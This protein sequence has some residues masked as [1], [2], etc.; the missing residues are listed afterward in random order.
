[1]I[2]EKSKQEILDVV[3]IEE[4]VGEFVSLKRRGINLMGL[5]PF[6]GEKSPSFN[7]NP[8]K[9]IFKCFGCGKAGDAVTFLREHE[10]MSFIDALKWIA[11]KYNIAVEEK[12]LSKEDFAERQV[13][14]SLFLINEFAKDYYQ[15]TM[16]DTDFGRSIGLSYFKERG[17]IED[18]ITKFGLGFAPDQGDALTKAALKAGYKLELL[19]KLK[20]TTDYEKDFFR[21]RVIFPIHN[22]SGKVI[23]F[24]GRILVKDPKAPKYVNSPETEIYYKSKVLYAM[25][26]A[27]KGIA[28]L[29]ECILTEGYTDVISLHQAGIDN[30]VAS[31]GTSLTVEQIRLIK[32]FTPNIK[33]L[34]DGDAAGIKAA[35]RGLDLV[36]E[37]NMNVKIVLL[38]DGEDPDSYV[39]RV[40]ATA[41]RAFINQ[42]AKDFILFKATLLKEETQGDPIKKVKLIR[43]LLDTVA[44]IPDPIKRSIYIKECS[45]LMEVEEQYLVNE[46]NKIVTQTLSKDRQTAEREANRQVAQQ[47]REQEAKSKEII[48][49]VVPYEE[50][51]PS[52]FNE[53]GIDSPS[54]PSLAPKPNKTFGDEFQ[55][56]DII[57]ILVAS[58]EQILDKKENLTV[59]EFIVSQ[60]N[61]VIE[62]FD[63]KTYEKMARVALERLAKGEPVHFQ[64][65][66]Q[67]DD[68]SV[69]QTAYDLASTPYEYSENW[70]KKLNM[71]LQTQKLPEL[72]FSKDTI[73]A[74]MRFKL[75]RVLRLSDKNQALLKE[76]QQKG[77]TDQLWVVLKTQ[78]RLK[79]MSSSI[80]KQLGTVIL[81]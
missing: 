45:A 44:K 10:S 34:Y 31:S 25:H 63:N 66:A 72:N 57:R 62:D 18:T 35:L 49:G 30:V 53:A 56:R 40:G 4:V 24:A 14:E 21:G 5:C 61:E 79:E 47:Q 19:K 78:Q 12:E 28:Q 37:Q 8:G 71:P 69:R 23:A 13:E 77:D 11:K 1:M 81:R 15:K 46:V 17:F 32:R 52:F 70:E 65:F 29:D 41:F 48:E 39:Q 36:L 6:H 74:V 7:V 22:L 9:N 55:E 3:R 20:L 75:R 50:L 58:G 59:A 60:I 68:S 54:S 2:T 26:L 73:Q 76:L 80:A 43:E 51:D 27:K 64:F 16:F 67:H 33:I 38:P 42:E